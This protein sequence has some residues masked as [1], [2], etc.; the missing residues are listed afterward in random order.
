MRTQDPGNLEGDLQAGTTAG[1]TLCWVLMWSTAMVRRWI[2]LAPYLQRLACPC[3]QALLTTLHRCVS[4]S[5][6]QS[7]HLVTTGCCLLP[8]EST[9]PNKAATWGSHRF[10]ASKLGTRTRAL[11]CPGACH[12][13]T[14]C[15]C[16]P[17]SSGW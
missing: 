9:P 3:S 2:A 5:C 6:Q 12:R 17:P 4:H 1:Y 15:R 7:Q 11:I 13:G 8:W 10:G 16:C 14:Y